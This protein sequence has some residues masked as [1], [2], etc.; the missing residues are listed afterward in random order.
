MSSRRSSRE[1][2][3]LPL[4]ASKRISKMSCYEFINKYIEYSL[5][6]HVPQC[7]H[8]DLFS[9][10]SPTWSKNK[11]IKYETIPL[12]RT[13]LCLRLQTVNSVWVPF[14]ESEMFEYLSHNRGLGNKESVASSIG[15]TGVGGG[16]V[17]LD[18]EIIRSSKRKD[19][20]RSRLRRAVTESSAQVAGLKR[21]VGELA[22]DIANANNTA[23][24]AREDL[25]ELHSQVEVINSLT[26][27]N[28]GL[29]TQMETITSPLTEEIKDLKKKYPLQK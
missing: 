21:K 23:D 17:G 26:V 14:S 2:G 3:A 22:T 1:G 25:F 4:T 13:Y 16:S 6:N 19:R 15:G 10:E 20:E 12:P 11:K 24:C 5:N 18:N 9:A 7:S 29:K 27:E 28:D 8:C